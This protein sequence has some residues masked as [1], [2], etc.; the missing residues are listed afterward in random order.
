MSQRRTAGAGPGSPVRRTHHIAD[1]AHHFLGDDR[2]SGRPVP[3]WVVA[4][5]GP[6]PWSAAAALELARLAR[7]Q[8]GQ[9]ALL[10]EDERVPWSV[11]ANL[12]ARDGEITLV[13]PGD[14]AA[15]GPGLAVW[16]LGPVDEATLDDYEA[17]RRVAGCRLPGDGGRGPLVWCVGHGEAAG[18]STLPVL[19]RLVRLL[20]PKRLA[21]V[22]VPELPPVGGRPNRSTAPDPAA[23][24]SL[25]ARAQEVCGRPCDGHLLTGN[26]APAARNAVLAL[27]HSTVADGP[28][29]ICAG[30]GRERPLA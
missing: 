22:C 19:E 25:A 6:W 15:H 14:A 16:H 27:V 30:P 9:P 21:V 20:E 7:P 26:M 13:A 11:A 18:W 17:A 10:A 1:I 8:A 2:A 12:S 3:A 23:V 24:R 4:A 28:A 5:S 29:V